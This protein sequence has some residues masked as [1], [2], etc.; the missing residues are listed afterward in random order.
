MA[1]HL[2][3]SRKGSCRMNNKMK[4][5][6]TDAMMCYKQDLPSGDDFE[7]DF[8]PD[9]NNIGGITSCLLSETNAGYLGGGFGTRSGERTEVA[10]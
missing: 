3:V 9:E 2:Q 8:P 5:V 4:M 10:H 1:M 6:Q 7:F